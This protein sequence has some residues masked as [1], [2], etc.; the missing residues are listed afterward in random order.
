[1]AVSD[2]QFSR[3]D[4]RLPGRE[5]VAHRALIRAVA[6]LALG[7]TVAYLTWRLTATMNWAGWWL[8]V[9]LWLLELH[10]AVGL[11]LFAFSLWDLDALSPPPARSA[12]DQRIA[13]LIPTLN[14]PVDV[15]LP[16]I[17]AAVVLAPAHE[18][19]VLDDGDRP[20]VATL[21]AQ[22]GAHYL[23]RPHHDHAKAGNVNH[24]LGIVDAD[25]IAVLDAD[26]VA[27]SGLLTQTLAYFDD[28]RVAVVQTP[29]DFYNTDS[30]EHVRR[31]RRW[32]ARRRERS[33]YQEQALFYRAIQ[34]GKNRWR[35]SFWCGTGAIIRVAAL[36][37]V[38]G[39][40]TGTVTEDIHTTVRLHRR[41]WKTVYHN[42]V[43][44]RGLAAADARQYQV[45]RLRWGTGAMQLLRTENPL[46]VS[47]LT[48]PQRLAYATTLLGWFDAWRSLGY[49]LVPMAVLVSGVSPIRARPLTFLLF[50]G[51]TFCLQ[52]LALSML[53]RG[54]APQVLSTVF[55]LVRMPANLRAT[56][57]L[58]WRHPARFR[59][60]P[61]GRIGDDRRRVP[62]PVLLRLLL[63][64]SSLTAIV[65]I[66]ASEGVVPLQYDVPWVAASAM[67]W[68]TFNAAALT[69]ASSR[70]RAQRFGAERRSS[71]RFPVDFE[72]LVD[73]RVVH[74][75]DLSLTGARALI[76]GR[77]VPYQTV[78]FRV[79]VGEEIVSL[80]CQVR[81]VRAEVPG[82]V[83]EL[84]SP[85]VVGLQFEPGQDRARARLALALFAVTDFETVAAPEPLP[86]PDVPLVLMAG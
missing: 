48:I 27:T 2:A 8:S 77:L 83:R 39:V 43:L 12:T 47:G 82:A 38:G 81:S 60:T 53:A 46:L 18:T 9:P 3:R 14:E 33:D 49:L 28:P 11:A 16:T 17:A 56:L 66:L 86:S 68:L 32:L 54:Y 4:L 44:A 45:Q 64:A 71:V 5:P 55:E 79:V 29:Q 25:L 61:K 65:C 21:A 74:L 34:P 58:W 42:E 62:V 51:L 70:I 15:L 76:A 31:S 22:L 37:D 78:L 73:D 41:G 20:E 26:H 72:A 69:L 50:F 24:A 84:N 13:V 59:V 67:L 40:A 1:M 75:L 57:T 23:T 19:W 10:A 36:S 52:R 63:L 7:T 85:T 35:A 6:V 80:R 30:F